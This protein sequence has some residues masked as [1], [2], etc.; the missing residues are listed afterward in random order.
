MD[1]SSDTWTSELREANLLAEDITRR[2]QENNSNGNL[3]DEPSV[4]WKSAVR[5]KV[6]MLGAKADHLQERL[7]NRSV[8]SSLRA[9][10]LRRREDIVLGLR[11]R[12]QQM[13]A[14]LQEAHQPSTRSASLHDRAGQPAAGS[15][16]DEMSEVD[17]RGGDLG[18][19]ADNWGLVRMQIEAMQEQEDE[20]DL[21]HNSVWK[22]KH[23]ALAINGELDLQTRLLDDLDDD[24]GTSRSRVQGLQQQLANVTRRAKNSRWCTLVGSTG[25][26]IGLVLVLV[27]LRKLLGS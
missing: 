4:Q 14:S 17:K 23:V 1:D 10:E 16:A 15:R 3:G 22:A 9:E 27:V 7:K 21:M 25:V 6:T 2:I 20:M 24:L 11:C 13:A 12:M 18:S 5:R 19:E 8:I 26:I